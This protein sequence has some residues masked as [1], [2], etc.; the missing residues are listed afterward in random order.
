MYSTNMTHQF[1]LPVEWL[2][3]ATPTALAER[4]VAPEFDFVDGMLS[5]VVA[6]QLTTPT[7]RKT[8][9]TFVAANEF[10]I[11]KHGSHRGLFLDTMI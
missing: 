3:I 11:R 6:F 8:R 5:R 1:I 4:H 2:S 9:A 10:S 7:E